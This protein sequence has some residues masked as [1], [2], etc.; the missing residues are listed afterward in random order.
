M[1]T[2]YPRA[3]I[4]PSKRPD[5]EFPTNEGVTSDLQRNLVTLRNPQY[6]DQHNILLCLPALDL[7]KNQGPGKD[8]PDGWIDFGL[9]HETARVA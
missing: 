1:A 3:R 2:F 6:P 7:Y 5:G 8:D 9:H 4:P